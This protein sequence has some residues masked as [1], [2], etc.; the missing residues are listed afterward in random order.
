MKFL[1]DENVE[2]RL[3]AFLEDTHDVTAIASDYPQALSDKDVLAIAFSEQRIL[4]TND[5]DFG[6]LVFSH[7]QPHAGVIL[8][9]LSPSTTS[10]EKIVRLKEVLVTYAQKLDKFIVITPRGVRIRD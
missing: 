5:K 3:R 4:I 7:N 10:E 6:E 8:F 1:L 9:R 2:F